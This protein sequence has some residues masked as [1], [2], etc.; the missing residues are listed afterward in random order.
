[1]EL[2]LRFKQLVLC[3]NLEIGTYCKEGLEFRYSIL[4]LFNF[5]GIKSDKRHYSKTRNRETS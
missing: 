3:I 1:M 4:K 2:Y 5:V